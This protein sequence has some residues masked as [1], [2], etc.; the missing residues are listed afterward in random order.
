[1]PVQVGSDDGG[2]LVVALVVVVLVVT[3]VPVARA[4]IAKFVALLVV[5]A[6]VSRGQY[7]E[8]QATWEHNDALSWASA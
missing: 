1:M 2:L 5:M 7:G 6:W 3:L 4:A 8:L